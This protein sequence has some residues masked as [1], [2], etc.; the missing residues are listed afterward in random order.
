MNKGI[1]IKLKES[2][3]IKPLKG[4]EL[5]TKQKLQ[6]ISQED[7]TAKKKPSQISWF[8]C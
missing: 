7:I 2:S 1:Q 5:Q 3:F 8:C 6:I 4:L